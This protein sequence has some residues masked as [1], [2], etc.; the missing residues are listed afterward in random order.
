MKKLMKNLSAI[1][2]ATLSITACS[3]S[4]VQYTNPNEVNTTSIDFNQTDLQQVAS[5]MVQ[6]LLTFT[7]VVELTSQHRPVVFVDHLK[8]MT[9]EHID[10]GAINDTITTKLIQSGKF[11]FVDM[12]AVAAVTKQLDYQKDSGLVDPS[13]AINVGHQMGAQFMLY[14]TL[15]NMV[16]KTNKVTDVYFLMTMK[17][18]NLETGII[19]W[20][21]QKQIRKV[22][23][24][25]TF[26]F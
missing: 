23:T 2:C 7:P 8:N 9:D 21:G 26:G 14:G 12:D 10:M 1:V 5:G 13:S 15:T 22:K 6:S 18:M 11:R 4:K 3:S 17:L 16:Q 19:E 25:S 20:Q 24:K